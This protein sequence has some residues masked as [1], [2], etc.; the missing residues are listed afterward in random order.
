VYHVTALRPSISSDAKAA[1]ETAWDLVFA[2]NGDGDESNLDTLSRDAFEER[3]AESEIRWVGAGESI[4]L[5]GAQISGQNSWKWM[6]LLVLMF[7]LAELAI[8]AWPMVK[9]R[10]DESAPTAATSS[11]AAA[12]TN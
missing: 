5:A 7:L 12:P 8:L 3:G 6:I 4:S 11:S 1:T 2:V 9:A 10:L